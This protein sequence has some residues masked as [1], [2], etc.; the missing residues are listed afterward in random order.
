M[1]WIT[2]YIAA[3]A[4]NII[5]VIVF[6][7]HININLESI[8]PVAMIGLSIFEATYLANDDNFQE[9]TM[10]TSQN[11]L[12]DNEKG[13]MYLCMRRA[14]LIAIPLFVPFIFFFSKWIKILS[15][16]IMFLTLI[17]GGLYFRIRHGKKVKHRWTGESEE[18][19]EQRKKEEMG[20]FK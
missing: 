3:V 11:S 12:N 8:I 5:C 7:K 10:Y 2:Y 19:K 17:G 14:F 9:N 18:L 20:K 13:K 4:I 6:R 15:V 16:L 1:G